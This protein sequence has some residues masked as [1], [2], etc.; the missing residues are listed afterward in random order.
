MVEKKKFKVVGLCQFK[1]IEEVAEEI[2]KIQIS[3]FLF[4]FEGENEEVERMRVK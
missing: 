3:V 4:F 2:E 1:G